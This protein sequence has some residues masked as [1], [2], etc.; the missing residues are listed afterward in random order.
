MPR[1]RR[2]IS[3][4]F[5]PEP[6][7]EGLHICYLYF[8]DAERS[9]VVSSYVHS[10]L[11]QGETVDY[12]AHA[13][14]PEMLQGRLEKL[15]IAACAREHPRQFHVQTAT[16]A[17]CP[18]GHFD[19]E[20]ILAKLRAVALR[21]RSEGFAGAR[22]ASEADWVAGNPEA[23]R[24]LSFEEEISDTL[25]AAPLTLLCQYDTRK[26]S[27]AMIFDLLNA[28]PLVLMRGQIIRNP[29]YRPPRHGCGAPGGS[30]A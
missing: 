20:Q 14:G 22:M 9:N 17:Y 5:R 21:C 11:E 24:L 16:E 25:S 13:N 10:G 26:F 1:Q 4:G 29:Y 15:G 18:D 27:G 30:Q 19:P 28:H 3:L 23:G 7:P 6:F 8:D 12:M 2:Q